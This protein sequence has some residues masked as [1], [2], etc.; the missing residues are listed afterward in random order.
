MVEQNTPAAERGAGAGQLTGVRAW[1]PI[2][3]WLVLVG[4]VA[5][6]LPAGVLGTLGRVLPAERRLAEQV[7]P[8]VPLL[9]DLP[10]L[11]LRNP[12]LR[13]GKSGGWR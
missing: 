7:A 8:G 12:P 10:D 1:L 13:N 4:L 3:A 9:P 6:R 11:L 5:V 2:A